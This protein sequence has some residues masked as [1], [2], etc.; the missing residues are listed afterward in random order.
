MI[1]RCTFHYRHA[2]IERSRKI[3]HKLAVLLFIK[4]V[5][6]RDF[7]GKDGNLSEETN[8]N[9]IRSI[10]SGLF[11]S[12]CFSFLDHGYGKRD[13]ER[14]ERVESK[15]KWIMYEDTDKKLF[16]EVLTRSQTHTPTYRSIKKARMN[17][18]L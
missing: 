15:K 8:L 3:L 6:E 2:R 14:G 17:I 12:A 4:K 11:T 13:R 5:S 18:M 16:Y 1:S 7:E 9:I 10:S